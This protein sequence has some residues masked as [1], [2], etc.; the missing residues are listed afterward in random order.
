MMD[1]DEKQMEEYMEELG[2]IQDLL[3]NHDFI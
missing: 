2:T 1:A 3:T